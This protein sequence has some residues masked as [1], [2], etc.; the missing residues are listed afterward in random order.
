MKN[1]MIFGAASAIAIETA[2][3]FAADGTSLYLVD[4]SIERLQAVADDI[5]VHHNT[6]IEIEVLNALDYDKHEELINRAAEKLGGLDAVLIAHGTLADQEETQ[7]TSEAIVREFNIN[8]LSVI[9]LASMA[10][11]YFEPKK[12]GCVAVIS[13]VAGDRGRQSNYLYGA[14]KGGVSIF[15]EG[16]R[17]RMD[18]HGVNIL[19][20]KPGMVDTPMTAH[21]PKGPLFAKAD[22]IGLGIYKAMKNGKDVAYLPGFWKL[23]MF[24]IRHIPESIFKKLKL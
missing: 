6:S 21:M 22:A 16:L 15:M 23:V 12:A 20:I 3:K 13:S 19:T 10:A 7:K 5:L 4:L 1:V 14:A 8:C 24:I 9:S 11:N 2:K 18:Q 17:N